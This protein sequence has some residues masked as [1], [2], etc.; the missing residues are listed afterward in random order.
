MS[1]VRITLDAAPAHAALSDLAAVGEFPERLAKIGA[2]LL[3]LAESGTELITVSTSGR[4]LVLRLQP[5]DFLSALVHA[6]RAM[7][8]QLGAIEQLLAAANSGSS[9]APA[10]SDTHSHLFAVPPQARLLER[11]LFRPEEIAGVPFAAPHHPAPT[12]DAGL[13]ALPAG[14]ENPSQQAALLSDQEPYG[15]SIGQLHADDEGA[16]G[17]EQSFPAGARAG[18]SAE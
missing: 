12:R 15:T 3:D 18:R 13:D 4:E 10:P 7:D 17:E 16:A 14:S 8:G 2:R 11:R 5:S 1:T 6:V 9:S